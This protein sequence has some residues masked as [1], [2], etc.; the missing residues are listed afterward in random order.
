VKSEKILRAG[1]FDP[2]I[3]RRSKIAGDLVGAVMWWVKR[4]M[5]CGVD[6]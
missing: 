2:N 6:C 4:A 5:K 1:P 3:K